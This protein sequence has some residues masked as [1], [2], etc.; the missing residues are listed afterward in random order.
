MRTFPIFAFLFLVVPI[1]EIFLLIQVG[2]VIGAWWTILCVVGTAVVGAY[3]LRQQGLST[4]A[5]FQ[6][7]MSSGVVPAKEILEGIALLI[8]GA[9]LMTPGFFTDMVGFLCL[10]PFT[11]TIIVNK[12]LS[13]SSFFVGGMGGFSGSASQNR[14]PDGDIIDAEYTHK[15]D[16]KIG[17]D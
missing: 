5:R 10:I 14:S 6:K 11:R 4:L 17:K 13:R 3:L 1:I 9:L 7:N 15:A 2:S 8:G 16:Q 12:V